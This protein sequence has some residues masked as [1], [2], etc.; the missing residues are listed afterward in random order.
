MPRCKNI[1]VLFDGDAEDDNYNPYANSVPIEIINE[2]LCPDCNLPT[3]R[4][5]FTGN[6]I[7]QDCDQIVAREM[8]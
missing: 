4:L 1:Q 3:I 7:C 2:I 5:P 6:L 8:I